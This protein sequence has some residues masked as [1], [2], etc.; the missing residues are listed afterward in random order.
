M[1]LGLYI[2]IPFCQQKCRYCDFPSYAGLSP[3]YPDY[4]AALCQEIAG[5][6]GIL[7]DVCIDTFYIG[8]GTPTLLSGKGLQEV[9]QCV[10]ANF[11]LA[12]DGEYSIEANPGTVDEEKIGM[13]R[14]AGVNRISFGVQA[15]SNSLLQS[16]GRIHSAQ[17]AIEALFMAKQAGF[18]NRSLDLMYGLPGQTLE[19][20][21]SSIDLAC[22]LGVDHL[23]VYGLKVEEGTAF[24]KQQQKGFLALPDEELEEEMYDV[25]A[26]TL[27]IRGFERYEIS[28]YAK[29]GKACRHNVK[30][31][32]WKPYIGI[33]AAAHSFWQGERFSNTNCV[34]SYIQAIAN[35]RSP[36]DFREV[37]D[38]ETAKAEFIFLALRTR[39]GLSRQAFREYFREE[40]FDCYEKEISY[41]VGKKLLTIENDKVFL[42]SL[43]MKYGNLVFATFMPDS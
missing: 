10:K 42:T 39:Q 14:D 28:N 13:L 21:K 34:K 1:N 3:L 31:W 5:W 26:E 29:P 43:G 19:D 2:H 24:F 4:I 23:S 36:V 9:I 16:L 30:Y 37:L 18:T 27:S 15:F 35:K 17:E 11:P 7:S 12:V 38:R 22:Q 25:V 8:G 32:Q 40:F 33:G 20:I 6:G 41:L